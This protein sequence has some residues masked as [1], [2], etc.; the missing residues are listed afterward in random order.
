[1]GSERDNP[2]AVEAKH[3]EFRR[4]GLFQSLYGDSR[5][6]A[7]SMVMRQILVAHAR[8]QFEARSLVELEIAAHR[9]GRARRTWAHGSLGSDPAP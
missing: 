8:A 7:E 4:T 2:P 6:L 1:M 9:D 3:K 5:S